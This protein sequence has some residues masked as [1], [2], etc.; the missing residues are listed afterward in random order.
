MSSYFQSLKIKEELGDKRGCANSLINIGL[1]YFRQ[2]KYDKALEHY[3]KGLKIQE[4]INDRFGMGVVFENI[5]GVYLSQN[6]YPEAIVYFE[7]SLKIRNEVG[8]KRGAAN[9]IGNLAT[10]YYQQGKI[11]GKQED[12]LKS[13]Q[14][15]H[16][17]LKIEEEFED[18]EGMEITLGN[19]GNIFIAQKNYSSG[20]TW[21]MKSLAIAREIGDKPHMKEAYEVIANTC[22]KTGDFKNAFQYHKL[23]SEMKDTLLNAENN[24]NIARIQEEYESEKKDNEIKLLNKDKALQQTEIQKQKAEAGKHQSQRNAFV[25]GF[26]LVLILAIIIFR[27]YRQKQKTN[28]VLAEKNSLIDEQRKIVEEKNKDYT[29]S[30][31]Y[32]QKIQSAIFPSID[33][34]TKYFPESFIFFQPKDIVSGDFYW[35]AE[36]KNS[37][38]LIIAAVDCTGHGVPGA[39]MSM[40]G[41][42]FLNEIVNDL[43]ITQPD[44]ILNHLRDMIIFSLKQSGAEGESQDGMDISLVSIETSSGKNSTAKIE[45]A[46]ANNPLWTMNGTTG[47]IK[48]IRGN[49][50]PIGY[51]FG[52]TNPFTLHT[53]E[54]QKGDSLYIF[55]DGYADQ[56]GGEN[57]KKF[58][59]K[60]LQKLL[61][62]L[63]EK[64]M[65]E[66]KEKLKKAFDDWK[67]DMIQID[68]VLMIGV[69]I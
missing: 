4:E 42:A 53:A 7:K 64:N 59:H 20:L 15:N 68:D 13:L 39:F 38:K 27:G 40:I 46:G 36:T 52:E 60:Q 17:A 1:V 31:N 69:K 47:E 32:A 5:G 56:F 26:G 30:V 62:S 65:N 16:E 21:L 34:L 8:D 44:L 12:F 18:K 9:C 19:I 51:Y 11:S 66:Q 3:N 41:N 23:F 25:I 55:S 6:T 67:G 43:G 35:F 37:G 14:F 24:K 50:F 33:G 29:D 49:S 2:Q 58:K 10:C 54:L 61:I 63:R 57:G 28:E 22:A 45:W 48:E